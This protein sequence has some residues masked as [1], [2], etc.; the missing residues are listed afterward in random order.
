MLMLALALAALVIGLS[1]APTASADVC[2]GGAPY[3]GSGSPPPSLLAAVPFLRSPRWSKESLPQW[4][5]TPLYERWGNQLAYVW[6]Q[7][8]VL[9]E[10]TSTA[11][12]WVIP[13]QACGLGGDGQPYEPQ[14]CVMVAAQ[15]VLASFDCLYPKKL[16]GASPPITVARGGQLLVSG[17]T[18]PGTGSVEVSF[19]NGNATFPAVGGVYGGSVSASLGAVRHATNVPAIA[20]RPLTA[21]AL[22]DQTGLFSSSQ[23]PLASTPRLKSVA[24]TLRSR[25]RSVS[26]T[27]LGTAVTGH[28]AHDDVLYGPGA[29]ALAARVAERF[30]QPDPPRSTAVHCGCSGPSRVWWCSSGAATEGL[31][32]KPTR[33]VSWNLTARRPTLSLISCGHRRDC[34]KRAQAARLGCSGQR[35]TPLVSPDRRKARKQDKA[36]SPPVID[37]L[38][39]RHDDHAGVDRMPR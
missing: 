39:E 22:V 10:A 30:M 34:R 7:D 19:Q 4:S 12:W 5:D 18:Q 2:T 8:S 16:A 36:D 23:G 24:A 33:S 26:A 14:V 27:I 31:A 35:L 32:V 3:R 21:V 6:Y 9:W 1:R 11:S 20:N 15:L 37:R 13:G 38:A 25:L 17:F 29:G 28:R